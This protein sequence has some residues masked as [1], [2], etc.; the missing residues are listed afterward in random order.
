VAGAPIAAGEIVAIRGGHIINRQTLDANRALIGAS[1]LQIADDA[2]LAPLELDEVEAV[3]LLLNHSCEP[4]GG[5]QGNVIFVAMRDI[6]TGEEVTIDYAMIDDEDEA[7]PCQC[8]RPRCR[9][10]ITGRD[11]QNPDRQRR[12]GASF[13]A[14]LL[15][16][17]R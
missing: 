16:K 15:A 2:F 5:L 3:M 11:W 7:M 6:R 10:V 13:S 12:Y 9:G 17:L 1:Y 8:G 4:N 14:Y